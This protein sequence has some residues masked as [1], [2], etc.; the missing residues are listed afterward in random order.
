MPG[1]GVF[2]QET[3]ARPKKATNVSNNWTGKAMN[4]RRIPDSK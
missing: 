4:V 1:S 3:E 2:S